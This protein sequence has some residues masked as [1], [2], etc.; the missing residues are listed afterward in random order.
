VDSRSGLSHTDRWRIIRRMR[1]LSRDDAA[2]RWLAK[3]ELDG[4]PAP[5][6]RCW[7]VK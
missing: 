3:V 2:V 5:V 7:K 4:M 1:T 6:A